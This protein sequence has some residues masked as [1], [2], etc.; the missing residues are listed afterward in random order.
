MQYREVIT[1]HHSEPFTTPNGVSLTDGCFGLTIA[2][3][4]FLLF[5]QPP[6]LDSS[7][8]LTDE[9]LNNLSPAAYKEYSKQLEADLVIYRL[10]DDQLVGRLKDMEYLA[11]A[12]AAAGYDEEQEGFPGIFVSN[13]LAKWLE[14]RTP[15]QVYRRID[16]PRG[17]EPDF[18]RLPLI[19]AIAEG[20]LPEQR[21]LVEELLA[22]PLLSR[23][24]R[25]RAQLLLEEGS[26]EDV[27]QLIT[28]LRAHLRA[29]EAGGF[30]ATDTQSDALGA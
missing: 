13:Y 21:V 20:C 1:G 16:I 19:P 24:A 10:F 22:H 29:Q 7:S 14:G 18:S 4:P 26:A 11:K 3:D 9:Q 30:P 12:L 15:Q 28:N 17:P 6:H 5:K 27:N 8:D 2:N 25:V 23:G